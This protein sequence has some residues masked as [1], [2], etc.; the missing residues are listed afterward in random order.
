MKLKSILP[1]I[2]SVGV[3]LMASFQ[4]MGEI[5]PLFKICAKIQDDSE[6]LS[7]YDRLVK[8]I[9]EADEAVAKAGDK[10]EEKVANV[11][12]TQEFLDSELR[13]DPTKSDFDLS[14]NQFLQIIKSA[15]L[16]NGQPVTIDGWSLQEHGYVLTIKMKSPI[17][18]KFVFEPTKNS[19]FSLLQPVLMKGVKIDP[20]LFVMNMA[21]RTM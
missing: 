1:L 13:V 10:G 18:I 15:K 20:A 17:Q 11:Q 12:P 21:A 8:V 9:S 7:C 3:L 6:R 4:A 2:V 19:E 5:E 16:E 14:V